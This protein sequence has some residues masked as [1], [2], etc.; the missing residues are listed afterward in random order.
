MHLIIDCTTTQNQLKNHGIGQY[1]KN[2]VKGILGKGILMLH[3]YSLRES[4]LDPYKKKK[5]NVE[6][7]GD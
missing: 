6:R 1:T 3:Y 2:I 5:V 4:T 7:I